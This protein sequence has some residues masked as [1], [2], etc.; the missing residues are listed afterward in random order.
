MLRKRSTLPL[1]AIALVVVVATALAVGCSSEAT[2]EA[3]P[4][5]SAI[6]ESVVVEGLASVSIGEV[7]EHRL[8]RIIIIPSHAIAPAGDRLVFSAIAFDPSG[9]ALK[10]VEM[11]WSM[12][13]NLA[14]TISAI[15]VFRAAAHP[16]I[17]TNAVEVSATHV[18][19]GEVVQLQS[20]ASVSITRPL[21]EHDLSRIQV[22][23]TTVQLEPGARV[24]LFALALDRDGIAI[25]NVTVTWE[26]VN[27]AAGSIDERGQFLAGDEVG[28][29]PGAVRILGFRR[30][31]P[32]Q[33]VATAVSVDIRPVGSGGIPSK[34]N[35]YPQAITLRPGATV[36]FRALVLDSRGNLYERV[37]ASWALKNP[38]A[39]N[40]DD[41]GLFRAGLQPGVYPNLVEVTVTPAGI[42]PP[43][44]LRAAATVTVLQP[45]VEETDRL[46]RVI[47]SQQVVRLKPG[48]S[49]QLTATAISSK[50]L[51]IRPSFSRWSSDADIAEITPDG[52]V[53]ATGAPGT[54]PD[55]I[56]VE[57]EDE[58]VTQA[59]KVT[60]IILGPL[61]RV[62]VVPSTVVAVPNQVIQFIYIAYDTNDVR[63]FDT[64]ATWELLDEAAG[65]IDRF[66]LLVAGDS[67]AEYLDVV[68]VTVSQLQPARLQGSI[69]LP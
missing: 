40:L 45:V 27:P 28:S 7:V 57:L 56:R 60:L 19:G 4:P 2:P 63:L 34:V 43:V 39:G 26:V 50:G 17:F 64:T 25:P 52:R 37:E 8:S 38:E 31:D 36:T 58:G 5:S 30:R 1:A 47:L 23:P 66:G 21:S 54:Y 14:G 3:S 35:L 68:K 18:L 13:D 62:E 55:A 10:D 16:G 65:R 9:R 69:P 44:V 51:G 12:K 61:A 59:S 11:R 15:G 42:E 6:G 29:F 32:T 46:E 33:T 20:L 48:E 24:R 41:Q 53:T 22:F 49:T 67:P